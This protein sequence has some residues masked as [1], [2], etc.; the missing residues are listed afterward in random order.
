MALAKKTQ[1]KQSWHL[2]AAAAFFFAL[3]NIIQSLDVL[4]SV[5]SYDGIDAP[6]GNINN[7]VNATCSEDGEC[8]GFFRYSGPDHSPNATVIVHEAA[9]AYHYGNEKNKD[10]HL[11]FFPNKTNS[12]ECVKEWKNKNIGAGWGG[13]GMSGWGEDMIIYESLFQNTSFTN[14]SHFYMEIGER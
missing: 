11:I 2:L 10:G 1:Q 9:N 8:K 12:L 14:G 4:Q 5:L 3:F 6:V 7:I 13:R